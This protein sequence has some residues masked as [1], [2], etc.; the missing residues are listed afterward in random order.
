MRPGKDPFDVHLVRESINIKS[1][2]GHLEGDVGYL[3]ISS[4]DENKRQRKGILFQTRQP[5]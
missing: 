5:R 4:F 1:A 2:K 3:R